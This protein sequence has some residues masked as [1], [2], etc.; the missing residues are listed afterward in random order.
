[1][2]EKRIKPKYYS[3]EAENVIWDY[4]MTVTANYRD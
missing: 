2:K 1:M 3:L 4:C